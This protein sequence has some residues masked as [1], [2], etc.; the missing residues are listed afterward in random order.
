MA[1]YNFF[2]VYLFSK[3]VITVVKV[4]NK[5]AEIKLRIFL[6]GTFE[7]VFIALKLFVFMSI[8]W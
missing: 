2:S 8:V 3:V 1:S 4:P 6:N 7:F 5:Y